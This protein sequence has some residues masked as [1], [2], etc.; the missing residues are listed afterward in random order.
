MKNL[1]N[2]FLIIAFLS[3]LVRAQTVGSIHDTIYTTQK[4][5]Q[6]GD[7]VKVVFIRE[8]KVLHT[9]INFMIYQKKDSTTVMIC[10]GPPINCTGD[11]IVYCKFPASDLPPGEYTIVKL[12]KAHSINDKKKHLNDAHGGGATVSTPFTI[13]E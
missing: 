10:K 6:Y 4:V 9:D 7:T 11:T 12:Y 13:N 3:P 1:I 2:L 8:G 5:Y